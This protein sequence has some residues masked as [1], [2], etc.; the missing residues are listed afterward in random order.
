MW[1]RANHE[2]GVRHIRALRGDP[3]TGIG[4]PIMPTRRLSSSPDLIKGIKKRY[5]DIEISVSAIPK[6][7]EPDHRY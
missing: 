4:T 7:R 2:I 6:I 3:T 1:W 5:P